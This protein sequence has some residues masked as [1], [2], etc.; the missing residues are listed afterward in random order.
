MII[1]RLVM[2]LGDLMKISICYT[3]NQ[4][5]LWDSQMNVQ[6]LRQG[7]PTLYGEEWREGVFQQGIYTRWNA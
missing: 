5:V 1:Q 4:A 7:C 2:T 3:M 6:K